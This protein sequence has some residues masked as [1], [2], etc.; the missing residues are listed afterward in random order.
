[1]KIP[2]WSCAGPGLSQWLSFSSEC[3]NTITPNRHSTEHLNTQ[4]NHH[5]SRC[6][7]HCAKA[8]RACCFSKINDRSSFMHWDR[9]QGK[10][11]N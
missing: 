4:L 9:S 6:S 3:T 10:F 5:S 7:D 8:R 2:A 11:S 1:M